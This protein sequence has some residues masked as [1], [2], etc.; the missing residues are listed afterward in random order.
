MFTGYFDSKA[1]VQSHRGPAADA[2]SVAD[3][4]RAKPSTVPS[5]RTVPYLDAP[6]RID[7]LGKYPTATWW[8]R[9][10]ERKLPNRRLS[11]SYHTVLSLHSSI[12]SLP[13]QGVAPAATSNLQISPSLTCRPLHHSRPKGSARPAQD[14]IPRTP[15]PGVKKTGGKTEPGRRVVC[16]VQFPGTRRTAARNRTLPSPFPPFVLLLFRSSVP[17]SDQTRHPDTLL[18]E[19]RSRIQTIACFNPGLFDRHVSVCASS[20]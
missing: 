8:L 10:H 19:S 13:I 11:T 2:A 12:Q 6:V 9:R 20:S 16:C 3:I 7:Y 18:P 15:S 4:R 5:L 1:L 17:N 14:A